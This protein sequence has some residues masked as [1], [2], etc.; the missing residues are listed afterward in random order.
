MNKPTV[1]CALLGTLVA[2]HCWGSPLEEDSLL[3][4][5]KILDHEYPQ[6]RETVERLENK[7]YAH[8]HRNRGIELVTSGFGILA[9]VLYYE[10]NWEPYEIKSRLKHYEGWDDHDWA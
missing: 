3:S 5:S 4:M 9:D 6:A 1:K 2:H 8:R 7:P 10:C